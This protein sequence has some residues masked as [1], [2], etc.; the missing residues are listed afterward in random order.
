MVKCWYILLA[1]LKLEIP[2]GK[3][4][5]L[6]LQLFTAIQVKDSKSLGDVKV[7]SCCS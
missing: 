3:S 2:S 1:S 5:Y 4:F 6:Q 7:D